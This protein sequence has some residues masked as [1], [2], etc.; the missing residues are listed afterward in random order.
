[1][2]KITRNK[3]LEISRKILIQAEKER[4]TGEYDKCPNCGKIHKSKPIRCIAEVQKDVRSAQI[5]FFVANEVMA[6]SRDKLVSMSNYCIHN[7]W[8]ERR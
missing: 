3:A 5:R 7:Q 1:M 6:D 8:T 2:K 4:G